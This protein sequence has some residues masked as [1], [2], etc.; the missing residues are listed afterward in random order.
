MRTS[1]AFLEATQ[2]A[3]DTFAADYA[4][5]TQDWL[6]AA[7]F[8][9]AMVSTFVDL[10]LPAGG[11]VADIGCGP[12]HLTASLATAGL[13]VSGVDLSPA[14]IDLARTYHPELSFEVGTMTGLTH[15]DGSLS[16]LIS[17][18]S[19]MHIP[20]DDLAGVFAEYHRVLAPGG[21][22]LLAYLTGDH[23]LHRT[24]AFG[25]AIALDYHLRPLPPVVERLVGVGFDPIAQARRE[26]QDDET[27]P[28]AYV[29]A[30]KPAAGGLRE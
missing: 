9:R 2:T 7:P 5:Q 23:L 1:P 19:I 6:K 15:A 29:L 8:D 22:V 3:Y 24:E 28:R 25:R 12:G 14:M 26:P 4:E 20:T 11:P 27:I 18:Y 17:M 21:V 16:G 30:R 13:D 10:V